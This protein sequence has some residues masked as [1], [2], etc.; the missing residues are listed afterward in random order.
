MAGDFDPLPFNGRNNE[1]LRLGQ[2]IEF[3]AHF[4]NGIVAQTLP[5]NMIIKNKLGC[6]QNRLPLN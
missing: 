1:W 5:T 2:N 3:R 4:R 6:F